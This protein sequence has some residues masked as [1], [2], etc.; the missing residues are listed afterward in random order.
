MQDQNTSHPANAGLPDKS[1]I[2]PASNQQIKQG[3]Q[4]PITVNID[5]VDVVTPQAAADEELIEKEWVE[6]VKEIIEKTQS[7]PYQRQQELAKVK[8][9]YL[10]KRYNKE[11]R[12]LDEPK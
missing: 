1:Q 6:K 2:L 7:N 12:S 9:D 4:E 10:K 8:A 5:Q 11:V 3:A